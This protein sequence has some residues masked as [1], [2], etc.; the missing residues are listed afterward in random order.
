[1]TVSILGNYCFCTLIKREKKKREKKKSLHV[2]KEINKNKNFPVAL[3][4][5]ALLS[6]QPHVTVIYKLTDD[7]RH[8]DDNT[9]ANSQTHP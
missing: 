8:P 1:M 3:I 7:P 6:R 4:S 2:L 9:L 5:S